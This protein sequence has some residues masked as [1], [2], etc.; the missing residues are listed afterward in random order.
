MKTGKCTFG[1]KCKFHHPI[2]RTAP[3]L[4]MQAQSA[5]KLTPAGLPRREVF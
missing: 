2:D 4:S 5:V 3:S 1:D